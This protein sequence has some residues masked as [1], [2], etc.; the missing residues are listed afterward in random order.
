[1]EYRPA[2]TGDHPGVDIKHRIPYSVSDSYL[3]D[4]VYL[5]EI[6]NIPVKK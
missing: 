3:G 4:W 5:R 2:G 1:M 6:H